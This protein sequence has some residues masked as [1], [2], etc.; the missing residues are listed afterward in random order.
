MTVRKKNISF[1]ELVT[2]VKQLTP[3]DKI[4]LSKELEREIINNK[5]SDLLKVFHSDELDESLINEEV[6]IV[7]QQI[8][9]TKI[10]MHLV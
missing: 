10:E 3:K 4:K 1:K 7:R 6:E 8:Y 5:F 9:E 2:L